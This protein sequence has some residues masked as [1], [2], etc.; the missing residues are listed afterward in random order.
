MKSSLKT[1]LKEN[2]LPKHQTKSYKAIQSKYKTIFVGK[3]DWL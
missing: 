1:K 2:W 3:G